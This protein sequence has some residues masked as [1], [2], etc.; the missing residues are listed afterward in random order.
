MSTSSKPALTRQQVHDTLWNLAAKHTDKDPGTIQPTSRLAQDLGADSLQIVELTMELEEQL[1]ITLPEEVADNPN[2]TL[3]E[4]EQ[5][6][7][8]RSG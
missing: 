2:L 8:N 7:C 4:I 3:A 5:A 6:I 1:G